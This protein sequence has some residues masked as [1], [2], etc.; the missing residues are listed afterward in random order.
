MNVFKL[1]VECVSH[2]PLTP[3]VYERFQYYLDIQEDTGKRNR[4]MLEMAA[5][6]I[7]PLLQT[8]AQAELTGEK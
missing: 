5:K 2:K 7:N 3:E 4:P 6:L 1:R 8:Y